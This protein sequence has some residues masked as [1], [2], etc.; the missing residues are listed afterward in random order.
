MASGQERCGSGDLVV[1]RLESAACAGGFRT[2]H[3]TRPAATATQ[4][5]GAHWSG[6]WTTR[7]RSA[8]GAEIGSRVSDVIGYG[9]SVAG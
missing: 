2:P 5:S 9:Y 1:F 8:R 6:D 3:P 7:R 4:L